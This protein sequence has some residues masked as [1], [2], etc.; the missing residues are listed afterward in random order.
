VREGS[1]LTTR[2]TLAC[3]G[4]LAGRGVEIRG[5][6]ATGAGALLRVQLV[7]GRRFQKLLDP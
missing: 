6:A 1:G 7:D 2:W 4:S 5:L 3:D